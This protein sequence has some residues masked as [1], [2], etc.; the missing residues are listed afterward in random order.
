MG[1]RISS[2]STTTE[3]INKG[4]RTKEDLYMFN[5]FWPNS[6]AKLINKYYRKAENNNK[7]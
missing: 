4:A 3:E 2:S 1:H 5:K 6:I 7:I